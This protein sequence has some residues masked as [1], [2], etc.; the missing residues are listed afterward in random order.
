MCR[1][2][3]TDIWTSKTSWFKESESGAWSVFVESVAKSLWQF[4]DKTFHIRLKAGVF[5]EH[6]GASA[7]KKE[8]R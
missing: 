5:T 3:A 6:V 8:D 4:V 1:N 7:S 2:R